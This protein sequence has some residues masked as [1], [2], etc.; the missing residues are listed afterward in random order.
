MADELYHCAQ[1]SAELDERMNN[2]KKISDYEKK[3]DA[4]LRDLD[5]D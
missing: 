2:L 3:L 4:N 5:R 1:I